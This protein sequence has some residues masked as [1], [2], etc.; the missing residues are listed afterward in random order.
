MKKNCIISYLLL[1]CPAFF[2]HSPE[3]ENKPKDS[4]PEIWPYEQQEKVPEGFREDPYRETATSPIPL[5]AETK[6]GMILF[7]RALTRPIW[8]ESRPMPHERCNELYAWGA[9]GQFVLLNFAV[10]PL[11]DLK[12]LKVRIKSPLQPEI[13]RIGYWKSLYP[14]YNSYQERRYRR[15]PEY[16]IPMTVCNATAKEPQRFILSFRI[17]ETRSSGEIQGKIQVFHDGFDKAAILPFR[18]TVLPI[19]LKRDPAKHYTAYY[20]DIR[21]QHSDFYK[22]NKN[23]KVLLHNLQ[24]KE[25]HQLLDFGFTRPPNMLLRYD[26]IRDRLYV[27]NVKEILAELKEAGFNLQEPV[28]L[29]GSGEYHFLAKHTG[30]KIHPHYSGI[31]D[32]PESYF[33]EMNEKISDFLN[34]ARQEHY[35]PL[36]FNPVDEPSSEN[37]IWLKRLYALFKKHGVRTVFTS[38]PPSVKQEMDSEIDIYSD[39]HFR[40]SYKKATSGN[41]SE[42]WAYPNN[43]AYQICDPEIMCRNGRMTYGFGFWKS[44]YHQLMPWVWRLPNSNGHFQGRRGNLQLPDGSTAPGLYWAC[45]REGIYDLNYLYTLQDAVVKRENSNDPECKALLR[46]ARKLIQKT[47]DDIPVMADYSAGGVFPHEEFDARRAEFAALIMKLNRYPETNG[48]QAPSVLADTT[49]KQNTSTTINAKNLEVYP[50]KWHWQAHEREASL[51]EQGEEV[52]LRI[53]V[54]HKNDGFSEIGMPQKYPC[55]WPRM[56]FNFPQPIDLGHYQ[57]LSFQLKVD[58]NRNGEENEFWPMW[59]QAVA[60]GKI[61]DIHNLSSLQPATWHT[62]MIPLGNIQIKN[63]IRLQFGISENQYT[64]HAD[65]NFHFRN[66][67]LLAFKQPTVTRLEYARKIESYAGNLPVSFEIAGPLEMCGNVTISLKNA[68]GDI[69]EKISMHPQQNINTALNLQKCTPGKHILQ[70]EIQKNDKDISKISG[71]FEVIKPFHKNKGKK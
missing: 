1:L 3:W 38:A 37:K 40:F 7:T 67:Q 14:K 60:P 52:H 62:F 10:Y 50:L 57:F 22:R 63:V 61:K 69:L 19:K 41:K 49:E 68:A 66:L 13:T 26:S 24:L 64:D 28:M 8:A 51:Q 48:R 32:V 35:P 9:P 36:L 31:S 16:M 34:E 58:S 45:F 21:D 27:M 70:I 44:G 25:Y 47:W 2:C 4:V 53:K 59:L 39:G 56:I 18:I 43:V 12:K 65:L 5:S 71:S 54:D 20:Y 30:K 23:N 15:I 6:S 42:Y 46:N 33:T 11:K 17:P 55:G 29:S